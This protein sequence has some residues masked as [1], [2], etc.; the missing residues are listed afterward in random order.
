MKFNDAI[1]KL[2]ELVKSINK[3]NS[4]FENS[5]NVQYPKIEVIQKAISCLTNFIQ[6]KTQLSK[7]YFLFNRHTI[8]IYL[9]NL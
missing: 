8:H 5:D 1:A 4:A 3:T 7:L 2:G 9:C 6:E